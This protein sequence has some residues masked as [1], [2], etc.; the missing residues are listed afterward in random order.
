MTKGYDIFL[1]LGEKN[2]IVKIT[3]LHKLMHKFYIIP[4]KMQ[5]IDL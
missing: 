3:I 4:I 5:Y 2:I 1:V